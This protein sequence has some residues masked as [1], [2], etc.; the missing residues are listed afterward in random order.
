MNYLSAEQISKRFGNRILFENL[1]FGLEKGKKAALV[2]SNGAGKSTLLRIITGYE[3]PDTG[4]V[5]YQKGITVGFLPQEPHFEENDTPL[6]YIFRAETPLMQALKEYEHALEQFQQ[7]ATEANMVAVQHATT[8]MDDL[9]AW[10]FE[11]RVKQILTLFRI[12]RLEQPAL[13]LSGGQRKRIALARVLIEAPDLLILDEPTNHLDLDMIE[14]LEEYLSRQNLTLL[15][16]THD[17]YFLDRICDEIWELEEGKLFKHT[18]NYAYF[19]EKK[20]ERETQQS[21]EVEKARNLMR[22]ELDWVRRMPKARGTKAKYRLDAFEDLKTKAG[23]G[24]RKEELQL[25]M[26]MSRLGGKILVAKGLEKSFGDLKILEDFNYTFKRKER[27]GIVGPNGVGKSTFLQLITEQLAPDAGELEK[28]ETVVFGFYTQEGLQ[29]PEDKRVIDVVTEIAEVIP[30]ANGSQLTA[31]QF[32]NSFLFPPKRQYEKVSTL[33]GGERR[34]LYLLTILIKNP[35]F[36]ILDEPTNDLDLATMAR[37]E[38]FLEDFGGCLLV[39]THDR[40]F[41]DKIV[42]HLFVFEGNGIVKDFNGKY[43]EYREMLRDRE[44]QELAAQKAQKAQ[45]EKQ[46]LEKA[47]KPKKKLSFKEQKEFEQ[48]ETEIDALETEKKDL[49]EKL[50]SGDGNHEQLTEWAENLGTL[51]EQIEEK[52]LRWMEL[53]EYAT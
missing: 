39:V 21:A 37:L 2:A 17:R 45:E 18:G 34:R 20:A 31:S 12:T 23:S 22:K 32:L 41:M 53:A 9:K 44:Q 8:R 4:E 19:L 38:E 36:L 46:K 5:A 25:N 33:S 26:K 49:E 47:N 51:M 29:L 30:A 16:V 6:S 11:V 7:V 15:L 24:K 3:A 35:N 27:L 1:N 40:Y 14:W 52:T 50:N 42:D 10:D 28:G 48:L 13:E 43:T